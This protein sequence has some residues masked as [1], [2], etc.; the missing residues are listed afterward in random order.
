MAFEN[1]ERLDF[2][3]KLLSTCSMGDWSR[4]H[5]LADQALPT[6][7]DHKQLTRLQGLAPD[8]HLSMYRKH[9]CQRLTRKVRR[10][11]LNR[12]DRRQQ[13]LLRDDMVEMGHTTTQPAHRVRLTHQVF[14]RPALCRLTKTVKGPDS[15]R[16]QDSHLQ[17]MPLQAHGVT[18]LLEHHPD[19]LQPHADLHPRVF[20]LGRVGQD[21]EV[22]V[23]EL[24]CQ[25]ST[26]RWRRLDR[27][28]PTEDEVV[29]CVRTVGRSERQCNH[30][31]LH[32]LEDHPRRMDMEPSKIFSQGRI[33]TRCH[34]DL[35]RHR[36][37]MEASVNVSDVRITTRIEGRREGR[38]ATRVATMR[39][40]E[41]ESMADGEM[42]G[43]VKKIDTGREVR[44][45]TRE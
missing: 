1:L 10:H 31:P 33:P 18:R 35:D 15:I 22:E 20:R 39:T 7:S 38:L 23:G 8:H 16:V 4:R 3:D 45:E 44:D 21:G 30:H 24:H 6:R 32:H 19:H 41:S 5:L 40:E 17:I 12:I 14:I 34:L 2:R 27:G 25:L 13:V 36:H 26:I 11:H 43:K 28:P 37:G 42:D 9:A 29:E